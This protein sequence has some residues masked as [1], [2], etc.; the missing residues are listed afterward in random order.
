M[1]IIDQW[2]YRFMVNRNDSETPERENY[3]VPRGYKTCRNY[4]FYTILPCKSTFFKKLV[5]S[6]THGGGGF[7][8][9][10]RVGGAAHSFTM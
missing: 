3:F 1:S 8:A 5:Y 9:K 4:E 2:N 10:F 7:S 6:L